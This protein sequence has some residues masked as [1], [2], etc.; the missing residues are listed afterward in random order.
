VAPGSSGYRYQTSTA[1]L[2]PQILVHVV[3]YEAGECQRIDGMVNRTARWRSS[4]I[5]AVYRF[6]ETTRNEADE[7]VTTAY[8]IRA[9]RPRHLLVGSSR[10]V[11]GMSIDR[12]AQDEFFNASM[13]RASLA[14]IA[15]I[16]RLAIANPRL[17]QVIWGV[18][19]YAFDERFVGLRHLRRA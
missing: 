10:V 11:V 16:L 3:G 19:F 4:V 5:P 18:D 15:A 6:G 17:Q 1:A 7:R 8:R 12:G 14:E 13:S 9:E 2:Q